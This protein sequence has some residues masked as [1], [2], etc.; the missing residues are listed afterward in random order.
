MVRLEGQTKPRQTGD[1]QLA[2]ANFE[3]Q[4]AIMDQAEHQVAYALSR[5]IEVE[6]RYSLLFNGFSFT[7]EGIVVVV[8][9][10]MAGE[11]SVEGET[12]TFT[13]V[14]EGQWYADAVRGSWSFMRRRGAS[15]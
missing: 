2:S 11:P 6:N 8:L 9:Y 14:D 7:G 10:R 4:A 13:N 12:H 15:G 3:D 5:N 1:L